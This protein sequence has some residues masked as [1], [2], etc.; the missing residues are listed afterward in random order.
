MDEMILDT[1]TGQLGLFDDTAE[2]AAAERAAAERAAATR[3]ALSQRE[4][5]I[6]AAL[7][8]EKGTT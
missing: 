5:D 3:W 8:V 2:R 7:G 1:A 6:V 4:K